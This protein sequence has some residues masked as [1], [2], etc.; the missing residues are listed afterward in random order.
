MKT[1]TLTHLDARKMTFSG[2][3]NTK[4]SETLPDQSVTPQELLR[5]YA[6]GQP[7]GFKN[8]Q[9]VYDDDQNE[10]VPEF[11]KLSKLDRLHLLQTN[12]EKVNDL[13]SYNKAEQQKAYEAKR[14]KQADEAKNERQ[15]TNS[16]ATNDEQRV[17][18]TQSAQT[19]SNQN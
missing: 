19:T 3:V 15:T 5:R 9:P 2:E 17:Q 10:D 11:Y 12:S 8:V 1:T 4:D 16:E 13:I 6:T 18:N 14:Q 7:L